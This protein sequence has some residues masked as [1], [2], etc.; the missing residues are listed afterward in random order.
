MIPAIDLKEGRCVRLKQGLMREETVFSSHPEK[1]ALKWMKAGAERIHVVD[2]DGAAAG[3]PANEDA[4][5]GIVESVPIPIQVGGGI[6]HMKVLERYLEIGVAQVILG[7]AACKNPELVAEA[8]AAFPNRIILGIDAREE[9]VAIEGWTE[10]TGLTPADMAKN[11]EVMGIAAVIYT[12][13]YRDGMGT[14][15]NVE[16]TRNLARLL[17]VPVIAS[18]GIG[19]ISDV[20]K[21]LP[22]ARDGVAGMIT[23]RA[24]YDGSLDLMEAIR[25]AR[26]TVS[27]SFLP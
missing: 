19:G 7:T 24:L 17:H 21:L 14:G 25:V 26:D 20:M 23:G 13:I 6:R 1:M 9:R 11:F 22:L 18:G 8:C 3:H 4:V 10:D 16:A 27:T 15:P 5:R 12:D 2:L